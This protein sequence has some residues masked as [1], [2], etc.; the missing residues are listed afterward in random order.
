MRPRVAPPVDPAAPPVLVLSTHD[1]RRRRQGRTTA[2]RRVGTSSRPRTPPLSLA[3]RALVEPHRPAARPPR[4]RDDHG[5]R[6]ARHRGRARPPR[7]RRRRRPTGGRRPVAAAGRR[8]ACG[9][10]VRRACGRRHAQRASR[11][12]RRHDGRPERQVVHRKL[13][14]ERGAARRGAHLQGCRRRLGQPRITADE[15]QRA[16]ARQGRP[17]PGRSPPGAGASTRPASTW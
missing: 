7:P 14:C 13:R 16:V 3:P 1:V 5:R 10:A 12:G 9:R 2:L 6:R 17:L 15:H 4:R 8:L 11:L